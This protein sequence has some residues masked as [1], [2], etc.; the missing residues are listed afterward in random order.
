MLAFHVLWTGTRRITIELEEERIY[1]TDPYEI[2][3]NGCHWGEAVR[4]VQTIT[5]LEPDTEYNIVITRGEE[6]FEQTAVTGT[7]QITLDVRAFG[8]FGDGVHND[9]N[10]IQAAIL[11]CPPDGRVY[12]PAG[13][14]PVTNL[15]LK[16]DL[17]IEIGKDAALL[18]IYDRDLIPILPGQIEYE[19][20]NEYYNLG[21]WEGNPLDC[22]ASLITGV[23]VRN[24]VICGEGT[25]DGRADF[26]NWWNNCKVRNRAWRPRMIFLNHCENIV[27]QGI[28]VQNS[29]AWNL[30]PYFSENIRFLDMK[31]LGPANSHNTDGCDPESCKHVDIIGVYFSVGDDCIAVKSGKIYMG[32]KFKVPCEDIRIRQSLMR[33]G[34]GAVTLGSE[35]AAGVKNF[36]VEKCRFI[37][38]DR[39]L[40][41]KTRRG[42]G[43]DSVLDD[44]VFADLEMDGVK[45]P[46]VVNSFYFC[47]PD[48]HSE[49]VGTKKALPVDERTPRIDTM[50]FERI[51]CR[52]AH[53]C[54]AYIYGLP[55]QKIERVVFDQVSI[56]YAE[57]AQ[58]G[59][60]AMMESCE[61]A[62]RQGIVLGNVKEA[63]LRNV[64]ITGQDG[65]AVVLD[66]VEHL[67]TEE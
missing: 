27:V 14:Y 44:I 49:Y 42:R 67:V 58:T 9:T 57:D 50:S 20:E 25:I 4:M 10:A 6:R 43:R 66:G 33:D 18:G 26:T 63:V 17:T 62:S 21:S 32:K 30:H 19:K 45:A 15:F 29:P 24:V 55:E 53:F 56:T 1:E 61:P 22:F 37:N 5:G 31:V 12:I 64:V 8:A 59:T 38:T 51:V 40:R 3:V 34:H 13:N 28:T 2:S 54:G 60:A 41:V 35:I 11:C 47:D 16:S 36:R 39:G 48:G 46:F 23:S 52:N 65:D 7:E